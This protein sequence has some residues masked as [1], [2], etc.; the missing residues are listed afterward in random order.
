MDYP[1]GQRRISSR[2]GETPTSGMEPKGTTFDDIL[3]SMDQHESGKGKKG[4]K[5]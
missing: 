1:S 2:S 4:K 5:W 3:S